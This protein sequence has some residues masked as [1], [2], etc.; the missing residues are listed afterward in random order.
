MCLLVFILLGFG[1]KASAANIFV[2]TDGHDTE[3]TGLADAAHVPGGGTGQSCAFLT[4]S[5]A[6]GICD[7]SDE[8]YTIS[9]QP[10]NYY[11]ETYTPGGARAGRTA[12]FQVVGGRATIRSIA[13][14]PQ[15]YIFREAT[16]IGIGTQIFKNIDFDFDKLGN[17]T[18]NLTRYPFYF[19][20]A[21][22]PLNLTLEDCTAVGPKDNSGVGSVGL[23]SAGG[24]TTGRLTIKRCDISKWNGTS[25]IFHWNGNG[26]TLEGNYIHDVAISSTQDKMYVGVNAPYE[27][28]V[29]LRNN[30]LPG[31]STA[32]TTS[33]AGQLIIENNISYGV[34]AG[35]NF[36]NVNGTLSIENNNVF[37]T[38]VPSP[39]TSVG[40]G[41]LYSFSGTGVINFVLSSTNYY[42]DPGFDTAPTLQS[43]SLLIGRGKDAGVQYDVNG[44]AFDN[45]NLPMIGCWTPVSG[46]KNYISAISKKVLVVGDSL[47]A[48][49]SN[50]GLAYGGGSVWS[51]AL[52]ADPDLSG[53]EWAYMP[54]DSDNI[55]LGIS[56]APLAP[57]RA[58]VSEFAASNTPEYILL[59]FG[60]NNLGNDGATSVGNQMIEVLDMLGSLYAEEERSKIIYVGTHENTPCDGNLTNGQNAEAVV[61]SYVVAEGYSGVYYMTTMPSDNPDWL[62]EYYTGCSGNLHPNET[63]AAY[64]AS[65][66][67]PVILA[68]DD[69]TVTSIS[70]ASGTTLGGTSVILT[71]TNF[72]DTISVTFSGAS[73]ASYMVD[74]ATQITVVTPAHTIGIVDVVVTTTFGTVTENSG[75]TFYAPNIDENTENTDENTDEEKDLKV[76]TIKA[77]STENSITI[78]WKTSNKTKTT[79][80]YGT[81]K[82]LKAKKKDSDKEKKHKMVLKDLK[83]ETKY[84]FRIKATDSD[85]NDD[86]SKIRS[87]TTKSIP[88]PKQDKVSRN[89]TSS[90]YSGDSMSTRQA[91]TPNICSYT[92]ESGDTLWNIAKQIYGDATA[93]PQIIQKN[94]DKYPSIES[95]LSIGQELTFCDSTQIQKNP[96]SNSNQQ[97]QP[98]PQNTQPQLDT[99]PPV[100]RFRWWNPFSW[101]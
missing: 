32:G 73:A 92:V 43:T 60:T 66:T 4:I 94:K 85:G 87:I 8:D 88:K 68:L 61:A 62:A 13:T 26:M 33:I 27:G 18:D 21:S 97:T 52:E 2:R 95:K 35:F 29:I 14:N 28:D 40:Y 99:N 82:K 77:E 57:L 15:A 96:E 84:Y 5:K 81:D 19:A 56:G 22:S 63:G 16:G 54:N 7:D 23:I 78:T 46:T 31:V 3:C 79:L 12:T 38:D 100:G 42:M 36:S 47:V 90:T 74:S 49:Q 91:G 37:K 89:T 64:I 41:S 50:D 34:N 58:M 6:W 24:V 44:T 20:T 25:G 9:I 76:H 83:P 45:V 48:G 71:G 70:P 1:A 11:S 30:T 75:F 80:R 10:G 17:D 53:Y 51:K 72:I 98:Q 101:F 69:P 39:R 55:H 67:K 86:S 93:Y 65:V 59:A